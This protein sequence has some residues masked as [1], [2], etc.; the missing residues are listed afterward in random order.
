MRE[1][2]YSHTHFT[3]GE[4]G[5]RRLGFAQGHRIKQAVELGVKPS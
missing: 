3:D 2:S 4:S 5:G 1:G